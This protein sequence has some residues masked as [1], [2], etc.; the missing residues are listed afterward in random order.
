MKDLEIDGDAVYL[1][2]AEIN[3][4]TCIESYYENAR[5]DSVIFPV[6]KDKAKQIIEHLQKLFKM[7]E[8]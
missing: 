5:T 3:G 7:E 1:E 4:E 2:V 6:D 8:V